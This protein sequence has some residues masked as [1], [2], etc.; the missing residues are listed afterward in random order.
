MFEK[1]LFVVTGATGLVGSH[2]VEALLERG[3]RVRAIVHE[4]P[5][6][7]GSEVEHHKSDLRQ[8]DQCRSA[9][10]GAEGV[11]H[12]AAYTAGPMLHR[13]E[14]VRLY[15]E[16]MLINTQV[17][18]AAR[19][20]GAKHYVFISNNSVYPSADHPLKEEEAWDGQP[21]P[22][23]LGFS[24]V[25]RMGEL[26]AQIY[27]AHTDMRIRI[28][29]G[30]NVYGPRDNFDLEYSHVLPALLRKA[31]ARQNPFEVWG[32]GEEVRDF[33]HARDMARG[34]LMLLER[35]PRCEP[36]NLATGRHITVKE[37]LRIIFDICG[38]SGA[39]LRFLSDRP[40]GVRVKV[41]D[42]ARADAMGFKASIRLE[43]GLRETVAWFKTALDKGW[44]K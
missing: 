23:S 4:R 37:L 13:R 29:R 25:K 18:E 34:I 22:Q 7:F 43:E 14:P 42:T 40:A 9:C 8:M 20:E 26:Q 1:S 11:I 32:T 38:H 3:A 19:L 16:N 17:L 39:Q 6:P 44:V 10:R 5:S 21:D 36:V 12:A 30:G 27:A 28:S 31:L 15:T 24:W 2:V 41:I 33:I 35:Y